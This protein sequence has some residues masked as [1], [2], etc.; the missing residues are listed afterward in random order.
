MIELDKKIV[1]LTC[2]KLSS[3]VMGILKKSRLCIIFTYGSYFGFCF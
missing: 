3:G 1:W 2:E